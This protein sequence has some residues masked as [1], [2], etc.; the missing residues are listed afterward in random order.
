[1]TSKDPKHLLYLHP[2]GKPE[3]ENPVIDELTRKMTAAFRQSKRGGSY[4]GFHECTG[5]DC[6]MPS[7]N[8]DYTLPNGMQTNSLC[9]HY[10]ACHRSEVPQRELDKVAA[11]DFGE[12]DPN[13][14]EI[15]IPLC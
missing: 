11:L 2:K 1:M 10:L 6:E 9:I 7:A 13:E 4:R 14:E 15:A 12:E 5:E 8:A 3:C